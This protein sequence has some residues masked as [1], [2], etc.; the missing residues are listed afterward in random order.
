MINTLPDGFLEKFQLYYNDII[1]LE[2]L[3]NIFGITLEETFQYIK[4]IGIIEK[5]K[6]PVEQKEELK[7]KII[8]SKAVFDLGLTNKNE[9]GENKKN[10]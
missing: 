6:I 10:V 2:E 5:V 7:E 4:E 1:N 8:E 3:A 9:Y